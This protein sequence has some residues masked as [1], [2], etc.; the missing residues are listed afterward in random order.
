MAGVC[1]VTQRHYIE[2]YSNY[3]YHRVFLLSPRC[4]RISGRLSF[5]DTCP[6]LLADM[7]RRTGGY[8]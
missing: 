7:T 8:L 3:M 5:Q 2:K 4:D 1:V 6:G